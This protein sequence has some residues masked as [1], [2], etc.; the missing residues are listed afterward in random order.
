LIYRRIGKLWS[1][2]VN[3]QPTVADIT[4][5]QEKIRARIKKMIRDVETK[6]IEAK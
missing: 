3:W 5:E 6:E 4:S 2:R 1:G